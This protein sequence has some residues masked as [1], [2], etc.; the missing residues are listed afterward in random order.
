MY[1]TV[2]KFNGIVIYSSPGPI[3]IRSDK[4]ERMGIL[5][6]I[7]WLFW[8]LLEGWSLIIPNS[9]GELIRILPYLATE[10]VPT[11]FYPPRWITQ[12]VEL[13]PSDPPRACSPHPQHTCQSPQQV[14]QIWRLIQLPK[15]LILR[16]LGL[17]EGRLTRVQSNANPTQIHVQ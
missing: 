13:C 9:L 4:P 7:G 6:Y 11:S 15:T 5:P 10:L 12:L 3:R 17:L 1:I 8:I 14:R 16:H 2:I